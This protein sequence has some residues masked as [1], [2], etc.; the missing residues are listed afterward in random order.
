MT[1]VILAEKPSQAQAYIDAFKS[2]DKKKGYYVV[3]DNRYFA[4]EVI[5]T[6]AIGHLVEPVLPG[7]YKKEWENWNLEHLPIIPD[8]FQYEVVSKKRAQYN[9][10]KGLLKKASEIIIA[11][12]SGR[13]GEN[14]ARSIM[15]KAGIRNVPTKRLWISS[16]EVSE[17]QKG[18]SSLKNGSDYIPLYNEAQARQVADWLVGMN[19]SPLYSLL[20]QKKGIRET[21]SI[22]RV[23]TP[24]LYMIYKRKKDIENFKP[25]TY[26]ELF[27]DV[28]VA[29]GN[30]TAKY[31]GRFEKKD[32]IQL[33]LNK[34]GIKDKQAAVI[35]KV[36]KQLKQTASPKLHSLSTLQTKANRVWKYSPKDVLKIMQDLY[37]KKLL[38]Y[39][40]TD[41]NY[42]TEHEFEYLKSNL[43][44]Y[45]K[46]AGIN[47]DAAFM[48]PQKRYVDSSKVSDHYAII[49][50][51]KIPEAETINKLSEKE[52]NI[53]FEVL[54]NTLA[55]FAPLYQYEE[56]TVDVDVN[57]L[58]FQAKGKVEKEKGWKAL[59]EKEEK[60]DEEDSKQNE[61][62]AVKLPPIQEGENASS[63]IDIKKGVTKPPKPFTEGQL[64][65][66]M[67]SAGNTVEDEKSK[68]ILK[69]TEGLGTEAT[70]S[71]IIETLKDQKYILVVKNR[72]EITSKG[73]IICQAV[74]G[75]LLSKPEM[76]AKWEEY[77]QKIGQGKADQAGFIQGIYKFI[78]HL[79]EEVPK[80]ISSANIEAKIES[81]KKESLIGLCPGCK[82]GQ[83]QDK[84]KLYGCNEYQNGC[85][86]TLPKKICNK[87]ISK[88]NIEQILTKGKTGLIKGFISK[89]EK[90]FDAYLKLDNQI[91]SFEFP[92][93]A[94]KAKGKY[95]SKPKT[96]K[97]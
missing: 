27:S 63:E 75:N 19:A 48:E 51:K 25:Q 43:N 2:A 21:F 15:K 94:K 90:K 64:I 46:L 16:L 14:I 92:P 97:K 74:E 34:H 28:K 60:E 1:T 26:F 31:D 93:A 56:T 79:I 77:L 8:V 73:E 7:H 9:I 13:E 6:W 23:Q 82:K 70:R 89:S 87:T 59:F 40:R 80:T 57:G 62:A 45:Q 65:N 18:F 86:F 32:D 61:G 12:D 3:R 71:N 37:D 85:E 53:Y 4:G 33:L 76:T 20:L 55:M 17:V 10:V 58:I 5:V 88:T 83:I 84:G 42:I 67:K 11:T 81:V 68:K 36:D 69:K 50:T 38:T 96:F 49:P 78:N 52:K 66:L 22:G 39:P 30:F 41:S 44:Q 47:F 29:A 91:L 54:R 95:K 72:V 24:T 35:S